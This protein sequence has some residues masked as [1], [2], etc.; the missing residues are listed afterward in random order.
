MRPRANITEF[1]FQRIQ[2]RVALFL[3]AYVRPLAVLPEIV[4]QVPGGYRSGQGVGAGIVSPGLDP[5]KELVR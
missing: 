2:H 4:F 3:Q 5:I 1:R